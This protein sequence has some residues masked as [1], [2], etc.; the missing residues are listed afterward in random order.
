LVM[1]QLGARQNPKE[2]KLDLRMTMRTRG[3]PCLSSA[4]SQ[5]TTPTAVRPRDCPC[6]PS[7]CSVPFRESPDE[8]RI[9]SQHTVRMCPGGWGALPPAC[10]KLSARTPRQGG[11]GK[12]GP[13]EAWQGHEQVSPVASNRTVKSA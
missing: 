7:L 13:R 1:A 5:V 3:G 9:Q 6:L 4:T 11:G 2:M 12:T 8:E 10:C